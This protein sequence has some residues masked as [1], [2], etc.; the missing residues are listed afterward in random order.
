MH[1][2]TRLL[3]SSSPTTTPAGTP[4]D[5]TGTPVH[6]V[7]TL[8]KGTLFDTSRRNIDL[9]LD[10]G[11]CGNGSALLRA[12]IGDAG[13]KEINLG[14]QLLPRCDAPGVNWTPL[15]PLHEVTRTILPFLTAKLF[16]DGIDSGLEGG[17][18]V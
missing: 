5:A 3:L 16:D 8:L 7:P 4:P 14:I 10:K 6:G 11:V 2:C 9:A 18:K 17:V 1:L 13:V 12:A 15:L